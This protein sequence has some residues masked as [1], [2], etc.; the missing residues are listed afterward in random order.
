MK[1][2]TIAIETLCLFVLC[3]LFSVIANAISPTGIPL[4]HGQWDPLVGTMHAGGSCTPRNP[5]MDITSLSHLVE[6]MGN[7]LILV[8]ARSREDY[9]EGHIPGALS[10][11]LGEFD[12]LI[13]G[14]MERVP[15]D[16]MIITYCSGVECHDSH[17]LAEFLNGAGFSN[18]R[19]F[20]GGLPEWQEKNKP[21]EKGMP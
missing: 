7:E 20:A 9:I 1:I 2:K 21:V 10:L 13:Q 5:D 3:I 15:P 18:V 14:F 16:R 17:D 12:E 8:D 11:P 4:F 6:K 19:I